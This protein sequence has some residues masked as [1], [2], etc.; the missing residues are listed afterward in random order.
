VSGATRIFLYNWPTYAGTWMAAAIVFA[1]ATSIPPLTALLRLV[2]AT[3]LLWSL[4]SLLISHHV[5]DRSVLA[6]GTWVAPLLPPR[7]AQWMTVDAGLDAEVRLDGALPGECLA[8]LDIFDDDLVRAPS[9]H[10]ARARTPRAYTAQPARADAWPVPDASCDLVAL[11]FTAH[12]VREPR[13]REKMFAEA[14]RV[15]RVTG[16]VLLVEHVRDL[17]NF[18]AFGPGFLHFQPRREWIRLAMHTRLHIAHETRVTPW[19]M[20]LALEKRA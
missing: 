13:A 7:L 3:A 12:E 20:A 18:A 1:L 2:A 6:G 15:L 17:A 8:R 10:R 5:Y 4:V 9:V 16:R 14:A 11:V 19:V